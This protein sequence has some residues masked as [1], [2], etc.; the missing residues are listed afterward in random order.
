MA[1]ADMLIRVADECA[2][3][4]VTPD[5]GQRLFDRLQ[6]ALRVGKSVELDFGGVETIA[7]VFLNVALGKLFGQFK[8]EVVERLVRWSNVADVD[9]RLM[10]LVIRNAK[11]HYKMSP[12]ARE[13]EAQMVTKALGIP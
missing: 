4:C 5:D 11:A 8:A 1:G 13:R 7:T 3:H 10:R 12:E 9:D 6:E 2:V